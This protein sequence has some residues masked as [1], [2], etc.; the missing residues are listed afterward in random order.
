MGS[1]GVFVRVLV[2]VHGMDEGGSGWVGV[3]STI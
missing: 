1:M 2:K 3:Y